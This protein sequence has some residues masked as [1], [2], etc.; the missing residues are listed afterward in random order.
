MDK[1]VRA[2]EF[3]HWPSD[4]DF[5]VV[6]SERTN[7]PGNRFCES[8]DEARIEVA[9]FPTRTACAFVVLRKPEEPVRL[10]E[11]TQYLLEKN[12]AKSKLP[13]RLVIVAEM[14]LTPTRKVIKSRLRLP[15]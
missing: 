12:I 4:D 10:E 1:P 9:L 2:L 3:D 11:L 6:F 13:E 15:D 7:L 14:P 8:G 5:A